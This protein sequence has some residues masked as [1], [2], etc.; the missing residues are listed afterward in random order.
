MPDKGLT[1]SHP[2]YF[3]KNIDGT[4]DP[5][6]PNLTNPEVPRL[7]AQKMKDHCKAEKEKTGSPPV[8]IACAPDD[9]MPVDYSPETVKINNGF[10]EIV[11]REGVA[12]DVSVSE[13]WFA[14]LNKVAE[15]LAKDYPDVMIASNG[16]A[17][18]NLPP[19][20]I[21]LHPNLMIL[22]A[23]IWA[24]TLKAMDNPRSWHS[25][26]QG[27]TLKRWC[28]LN[29]RVNLY[30]YVY[31]MLGTSLAPVPTVRKMA[32]D[33]PLYKK[34]G[35]IG[36]I[37]E[38]KPATYMEQ[39]ITTFYLRTRLNWRAN[40]DVKAELDDY[41]NKWY[42]KAAEPARAFWEAL[43]E[44][45]ETTPVLGHE[46]RILP[47]VYTPELIAA[48]EKHVSRAE[49][50][51]DS[52]RTKTHVAIDRHILEHL[53]AYMAMWEAEFSANYA[54]A[55]KQCDVMTAERAKLN[56][57]CPFLNLPEKVFEDGMARYFSGTWGA[58][59]RVWKKPFY[60][61]LADK[62]SGKT[63]DLIAMG[64][65]KV[66]FAL[67]EADKGKPLRWCDPDFDRSGWQMVDTT[68]AYYLQVPGCFSNDGVPYR[69]LMWYAFD[70]SV[71]H[72]AKGR[73]VKLY[74]PAVVAEA[75][76]WVNGQYAGHRPYIE[77]NDHPAPM[78]LDV[79]NLL[80]P[81]KKNVI[82]V[83]VSTST[84]RSQAAEGFMGRLF[85]YSPKTAAK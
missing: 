24:D 25:A 3:A 7:V 47:N 72:S 1:N 69:G 19:E 71:P 51:A 77:P 64:D 46:E 5:F 73:T 43:E 60:Q 67:D 35:V 70:M 80:Q 33:Y 58:S 29:P 74:A 30:R 41:F 50:A 18:R 26:I 62:I 36:F 39:G 27:A 53:K 48:L 22:Y 52:E 61:E 4:P 65:R 83:R 8:A 44:R 32:H 45:M 85:L 10:T 38:Q 59:L 84:N 40:L 6:N 2:E 15:E 42:G 75:W 49:K 11:G 63:G 34:W 9:G 17:N 79:T 57:I 68:K 81:G 66:K 14:F 28:E 82:A 20:G 78:E 54:E 37:D 76:V 12:T 21:K 56:A 31:T 13:E 23:S 16:Y 55:A